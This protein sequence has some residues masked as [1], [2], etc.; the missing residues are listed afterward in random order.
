MM[1]IWTFAYW[2]PRPEGYE[3]GLRP[4]QSRQEA[5]LYLLPTA[6]LGLFTVLLGIW[7]GPAF[8]LAQEAALQLL[9]R[10]AYITAVL[11]G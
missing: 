9:D 8:A 1:K 7:A 3:T 5:W 11:G 4:W 6:V 10:Q 2:R